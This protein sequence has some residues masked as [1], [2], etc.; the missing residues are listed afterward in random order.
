MELAVEV[1]HA[2]HA[3]VHG[4]EYLNFGDGVEVPELLRDDL[5]AEFDDAGD[6]FLGGADGGEQQVV[7]DITELLKVP[8]ANAIT[9]SS[10]A[11]VNSQGDEPTEPA[12][13]TL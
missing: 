11:I 6:A 5:G 9:I 10:C 13:E 3:L 7:V 4:R 12:A 2:G 1:T 8:L